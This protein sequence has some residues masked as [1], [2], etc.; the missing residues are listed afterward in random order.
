MNE[1]IPAWID[2]SLAPVPKLAVH[3]MGLRHNAVSVFVTRGGA[4]LIQRRALDKY[5]SAGLWANTCCTH[6]HWGE[7]AAAC[8]RRR[9]GEE[10]GIGG[11]DG[12]WLGGTRV[13]QS[14][15]L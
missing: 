12:G 9:L 1:L 11:L 10:L 8:A 5:H 4:V 2:G 14:L 13:W 7:S 15:Y 6:P 3:R